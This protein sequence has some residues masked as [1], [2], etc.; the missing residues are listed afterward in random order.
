MF[1]FVFF[2]FK[3]HIYI[4]YRNYP[5][6]DLVGRKGIPFNHFL[7]ENIYEFDP[8][9]H[10][11]T[12]IITLVVITIIIITIPIHIIIHFFLHYTLF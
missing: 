9:Y 10:P 1:F 6:N 8:E 12:I 7:S 4:K 2:F 3:Y 11:G 5:L